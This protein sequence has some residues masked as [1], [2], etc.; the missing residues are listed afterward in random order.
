MEVSALPSFLPL[1]LSLSLSLR[2]S[3]TVSLLCLQALAQAF[4]RFVSLRDLN[5]SFLMPA[6]HY[7]SS[8][9][10]VRPFSPSSSSLPLFVVALAPLFWSRVLCH[11]INL[12]RPNYQRVTLRVSTFCSPV[13]SSSPN[14]IGIIDNKEY[15]ASRIGKRKRYGKL[16]LDS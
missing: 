3:T 1:S 12:L 7:W 10:I 8:T 13:L 16:G 2:P 14:K 11:R 9:L 15:P 5:S 6:R 4:S